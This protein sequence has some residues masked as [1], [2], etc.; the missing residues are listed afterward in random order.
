MRTFPSTPDD[1]LIAWFLCITVRIKCSDSLQQED[2]C[3]LR[4]VN[5]IIAPNTRT[6]KFVNLL[7][8]QPKERILRH[9]LHC[10]NCF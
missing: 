4:L 2:K 8:A 6:A 7:V 9:F 1:V 10:N 5:T 3:T